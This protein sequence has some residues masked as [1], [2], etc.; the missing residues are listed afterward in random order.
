MSTGE[1]RFLQ[2][3]SA[4]ARTVD[5]HFEDLSAALDRL[6]V[7]DGVRSVAQDERTTVN[8]WLTNVAEPVLLRHAP[9]SDFR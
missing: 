8:R 7:P 9:G 3:Y 4:A 6:N 5:A 1:R 2:P